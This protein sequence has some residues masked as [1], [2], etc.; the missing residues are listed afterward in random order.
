MADGW[1]SDEDIS[2]P[3]PQ[4]TTTFSR[5]GGGRARGGGRQNNWY[6]GNNNWRDQD[7]KDEDTS[8]NGFGSRGRR[9][10]RGG[11]GRGGGSTGGN[12]DDSASTTMTINSSDVGRI[13]GKGGAKIRELESDSGAEIKVSG[14]YMK[15][16]M[17]LY[18]I[19]YGLD[20][21]LKKKNLINSLIYPNQQDFI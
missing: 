15:H 4:Y 8:E 14:I 16:F 5:G 1:N 11:G 18:I 17:Y 19:N 9:G 13:I 12:W 10:G 2:Q 21:V 6:G 20:S 3:T 7:N